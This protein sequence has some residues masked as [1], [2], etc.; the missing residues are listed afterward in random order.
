MPSNSIPYLQ[1]GRLPLRSLKS[2]LSSHIPS[3][4]SH[5]SRC[6]H[7]FTRVILGINQS[8]LDHATWKC[9]PNVGHHQIL[10]TTPSISNLI[11]IK[12][13]DLSVLPPPGSHASDDLISTNC[14]LIFQ[15]YLKETGFPFPTF[16]WDHKWGNIWNQTFMKI[17][18][19]HWNHFKKLGAFT[20]YPYNLADD[21]NFNL[22]NVLLQWFRGKGKDVMLGH[23][24]TNYRQ[25]RATQCH[26]SKWCIQVRNYFFPCQK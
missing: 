19:H 15:A 17:I 16:A 8:T 22:E 26:K 2:H 5:F 21:N 9:L 20:A 7:A 10:Q 3:S 25:R 4:K 11:P 18:V 1:D 24:N 13:L 14:N 12:D 6:L 23:V